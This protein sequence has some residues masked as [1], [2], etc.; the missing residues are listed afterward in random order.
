[1]SSRA[2]RAIWRNPIS[3]QTNKKKKPKKTKKNKPNRIEKKRAGD[4][5]GIQRET[6]NPE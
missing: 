4:C 5:L 6:E 2:T 1:V 3:K